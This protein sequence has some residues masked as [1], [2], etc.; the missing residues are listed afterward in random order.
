MSDTI[1]IRIPNIGDFRDLPI[2]AVLVKAGDTVALESPLVE[3]ESEKATME[4]PS[5]AAGVVQSVTVKLGDKVSE[6]STILT[7]ATASGTT[8]QA[9][10]AVAPAPAVAAPVA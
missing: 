2:V 1:D 10:P 7:L 8:S 9:A 6:G 3:L 5:P 4:V